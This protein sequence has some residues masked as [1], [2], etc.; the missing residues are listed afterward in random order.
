MMRK[1][2]LAQVLD[3]SERSLT[4]KDSAGQIPRA[5]NIAGAK[6]WRRTEIEAWIDAGCPPRDQWERMSRRE[7]AR[8]GSWSGFS[9]AP[10]NSRP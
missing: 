10:G 7:A 6:R 3:L 8:P 4:R 2:A 1:K 5:V 9:G